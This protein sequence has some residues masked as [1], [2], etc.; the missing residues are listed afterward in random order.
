ML[1]TDLSRL[2]FRQLFICHKSLFY[3]SYRGWSDS[4]K[5]FVVRFLNQEYAMDKA[6]ARED[7]FGEEPNMVEEI[8]K[9]QV[10]P[11][12]RGLAM[13]RLVDD[14]LLEVDIESGAPDVRRQRGFC[15]ARHEKIWTLL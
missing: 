1:L 9:P 11:Q 12:R 10:A 15:R 3:E 2:D 4:K 7:L 8:P 6:G 13:T 5:E 14:E